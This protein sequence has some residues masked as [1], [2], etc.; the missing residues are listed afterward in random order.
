LLQGQ[1]SAVGQRG[2]HQIGQL[3]FDAKKSIASRGAGLYKK[4]FLMGQ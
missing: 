3:H 4:P 1:A 2:I